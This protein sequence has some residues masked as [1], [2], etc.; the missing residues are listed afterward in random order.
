MC[1]IDHNGQTPCAYIMTIPLVKQTIQSNII[2]YL[3]FLIP[4]QI[5]H[6]VAANPKE[7]LMKMPLHT[8]YSEDI[9]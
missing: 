1:D 3:Q 2:H 9:S 5:L 4:N 8:K 6:N 7:D